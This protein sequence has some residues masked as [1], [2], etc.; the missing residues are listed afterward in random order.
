MVVC[1]NKM[2]LVGWDQ[3]AIRRDR[4]SGARPHP[5]PRH[6]RP[7]RRADQRPARRQRRVQ[8]RPARRST[9]VRRCWSTSRRSTSRP[10]AIWTV[11]GCRSSGSAARTTETSGCTPAGSSP[12]RSRR[13]TRWSCCRPDVSRRSPS[14]TRSTATTVAVP[15]MSVTLALADRLDVGRGDML[16]GPG[17]AAAG[18]ARA[19]LHDLLDERGAASPRPALRA[20]AHHPHGSGNGALDLERTDPETLE[21]QVEPTALALNDIGQVTLRTSSPGARRSVR[22]STGSPAR[23]S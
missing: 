19:R 23:S 9:S 2:D 11:C 21:R 13:A 12:G 15:P 8:V 14:W 3:R 22:G 10:T 7:E 4:R 20:Q 1:V 18:R 17:R 5:A 16:V 6:P